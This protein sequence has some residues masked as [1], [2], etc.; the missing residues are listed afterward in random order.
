MC[1]LS[2]CHDLQ[3]IAYSLDRMNQ[4]KLRMNMCTVAWMLPTGAGVCIQWELWTE[5]S[6]LNQG[7]DSRTAIK[8]SL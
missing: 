8:I 2:F 4:K 1:G 7:V 5:Y 6:Q 3:N